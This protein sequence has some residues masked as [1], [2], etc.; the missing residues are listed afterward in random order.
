MLSAIPRNKPVYPTLLSFSLPEEQVR[1]VLD[2]PAFI[3]DLDMSRVLHIFFDRDDPLNLWH[4]SVRRLPP[5]YLD[6]EF[7]EASRRAPGLRESKRARAGG[8]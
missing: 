7:K 5:G 1:L 2:F 6:Y 3:V 4:G 8:V